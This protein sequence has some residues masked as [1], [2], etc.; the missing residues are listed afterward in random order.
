M[1]I[2]YII[3]QTLNPKPQTQEA[4]FLTALTSYP[5]NPTAASTYIIYYRTATVA[6]HL[7]PETKNQKL[8]TKNTKLSIRN[9]KPETRNPGP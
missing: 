4:T 6:L 9:Q 5:N 8:E 7:K 2:I 3:F 1:Y